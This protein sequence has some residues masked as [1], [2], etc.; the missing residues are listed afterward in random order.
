MAPKPV[1]ANRKPELPSSS[2]FVNSPW[3]PSRPSLLQRQQAPPSNQKPP[4]FSYSQPGASAPDTPTNPPKLGGRQQ[5]P[6]NFRRQPLGSVAKTTTARSQPPPGF[7]RK[8]PVATPTVAPPTTGPSDAARAAAELA[9]QQRARTQF[10]ALKAAA[11]QLNPN[12]LK[13]SAPKPQPPPP[14]TTTQTPDPSSKPSVPKTTKPKVPV[15]P[16]PGPTEVPAPT[17]VPRPK[18]PPPKPISIL[19]PSTDQTTIA[20]TERPGATLATALGIAQS[21]ATTTGTPSR[22]PITTSYLKRDPNK[23]PKKP[24]PGDSIP[25]APTPSISFLEQP[26]VSFGGKQLPATA[27]RPTQANPVLGPVSTAIQKP[28]P[29]SKPAARMSPQQ[30]LELE[31]LQPPLVPSSPTVTPIKSRKL[32]PSFQEWPDPPAMSTRE[33]LRK[34]AI[35]TKSA[36]P[37]ILKKLRDDGEDLAKKSRKFTLEDIS[38]LDPNLCPRFPNKATIR[39]INSD[40]LDAAIEEITALSKEDNANHHAFPA[41]VNFANDARPGG[42]WLNGAMAQEEAICYRS[43]LHLSLKQ[44]DYPISPNK[45]TT[46]AIYSPYVLIIR[47]TERTGHKLLPFS[48]IKSDPKVVS[49]LSVAA[50]HAPPLQTIKYDSHAPGEPDQ[51]VVFRKDSDRDLT[52]QKMRLVLR[53]AAAYRHRRIILGAFGCG[54][55]KNPPEDVAHCWLEVLREKEFGGAGNWWKA[56]TFAVYEPKPQFEGNLDIFTRVLNGQQV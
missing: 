51:L 48:V 36:L 56:V 6:P 54:V 34:V 47:G 1:D 38:R 26:P 4:R 12:L 53:T 50:I 22:I 18:P 27:R 29:P 10:E 37:L 40:T 31:R 35:G 20:A 9:Q 46:A 28:K 5:P 49:V 39:V 24:L 17:S 32:P 44:K 52:K 21:P 8:P 13:P 43:S 14:S 55:F 3:A 16:A 15:P 23:P 2:P 11:S 19:K 41:V 30:G 25:V 42:G 45:Y 7:N 33:E